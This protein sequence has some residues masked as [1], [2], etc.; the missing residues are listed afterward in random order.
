MSDP[1][2]LPPRAIDPHPDR[3]ISFSDAV[4][5]VLIT[6]MAFELQAPNGTN[7]DALLHRLPR[8]L[9]YLLS[10]TSIAIYWNN[11]HHLL[12]ATERISAA[13]MWANLHLL[14]WLSLLPVL[15]EWIG[16]DYHARLPA[17]AYG[18]GALGAALAYGLLVRAIVAAEG[19]DST[20]G[21]ALG[22]DRKGRVSELLYALGIGLG[23]LSPW[24]A[25]GCYAAV[26]VMWFIPDRRLLHR[27]EPA[28]RA[29]GAGPG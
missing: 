19:R 13:V 23:F 22:R 3:L 15:T 8:L 10:F 27:P 5:A 12:R 7:V 16:S 24:A 20:I 2:A 11:H 29:P 18:T 28:P 14:F 1:P 17:I 4:L 21:L 25:Y 9:V 6:I 26:A